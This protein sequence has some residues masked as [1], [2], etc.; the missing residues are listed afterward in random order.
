[1]RTLVSTAAP[2]REG[3][4]P[5]TEPCAALGPQG[6][7]GR[8]DVGTRVLAQTAGLRLDEAT[9]SAVVGAFGSAQRPLAIDRARIE[10]QMR[11]LVRQHL[12]VAA[13]DAPYLS[14]FAELRGQVAV[15]DQSSTVG[16]LPD[17]AVAWLRRLAETRAQADVLEAKG[18]LL[19]AIYERITVAGPSVVAARLTPAA[20][21]H[22]LALA[23][24]EEVVLARPTGDGHALTAYRMPIE[25]RDE[26]LA[27]AR[28]LA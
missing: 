1:M 4:A 24:P 3:S 27:A 11:D 26:R 13:G 16:I 5:H 22:R 28:R 8:R 17:R 18:D 10:R 25:G 21:R 20:Y 15:L 23:L 12:T 14:G 6:P 9:I 7:P 19:H 2:Q